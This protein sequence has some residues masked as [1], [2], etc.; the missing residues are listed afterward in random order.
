MQELNRKDMSFK[1]QLVTSTD[2]KEFVWATSKAKNS[3]ECKSNT[4]TVDGKSIL[5]LLSL[6][7]SE[8]ITVIFHDVYGNE[9]FLKEMKRWEVKD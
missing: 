7:L 3:V 2:P 6:N 8:P 9:D 4:R 5:G 1:I